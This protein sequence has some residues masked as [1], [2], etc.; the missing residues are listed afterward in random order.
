MIDEG[1]SHHWLTQ[2]K[3]LIDVINRFKIIEDLYKQN[4]ILKYEININP[5][6]L[7]NN[8][9]AKKGVVGIL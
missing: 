5:I 3:S 4:G 1:S 9:M 7:A 2:V 6:N 8:C